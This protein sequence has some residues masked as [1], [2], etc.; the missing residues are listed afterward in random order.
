MKI[1]IDGP[2]G[3]GKS[4]VSF[5][6]AQEMGYMLIDTGAM[7][8]GTA[9]FA[10]E[11]KIDFDDSNLISLV[12]KNN[13][14]FKE[15]D[16][17]NLVFLN[18]KNIS[19]LIRTPEISKAASSVATNKEI[20]AILVDKQ[21]E[22]AKNS[23]IVMEGRDIGTVVFPDA[24]VKIFLTASV[25][26]RARRRFKDLQKKNPKI[27]IKEIEED[28]AKRDFQDSNRKESPLKK[29]DDGI[30]VDTTKLN[31]EEVIKLIV[32]IIRKKISDIE[33]K[34]E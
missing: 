9:L 27:T 17:K 18:G 23:D 20:R 3:V 14:S 33:G 1:A 25:E 19:N 26:E 34:N 15:E 11:N 16:G 30:L 32:S 6:V 29:A 22:L 13:F 8:R 28:I 10:L 2:A 12:K 21:R 7:Y 24:E 4:S 5:G 31:Q